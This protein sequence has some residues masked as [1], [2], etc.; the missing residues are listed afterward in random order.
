MDMTDQPP[1]PRASSRC[2]QESRLAL[3]AG[4]DLSTI[5]LS[6]W[7]GRPPSP[8][9]WAVPSIARRLVRNQRGWRRWAT[10]RHM[11]D[12]RPVQTA[13]FKVAVLSRA[14][15][16]RVVRPLLSSPSEGGGGVLSP[17]RPVC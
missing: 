10:V 15:W 16:T 2:P 8:R 9:H 3:A 5:G 12:N 6:V 4:R 11:A 1:R 14:R 13:R 17:R 7:P